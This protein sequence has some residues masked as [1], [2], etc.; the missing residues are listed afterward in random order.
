MKVEPIQ[1]SETS[2]YKIQTPGNYPEDNIL[3]VL[4]LW[5]LLKYRYS[6]FGYL[7]L[8]FG[9]HWPMRYRIQSHGT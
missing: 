8:C 5:T 2:A 4:L 7:Q 9:Y 3:L 1:C 6:A